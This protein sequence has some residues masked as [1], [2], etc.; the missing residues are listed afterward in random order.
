MN[1]IAQQLRDELRAAHTIIRNALGV[2]T[3]DQKLQW[4][5]ANERDDAIGEGVTRAN[6]RQAVIDDGS[7]LALF[8]ELRR[9]DL[10]IANA[11]EIQSFHQHALWTT[12][13][14]Q[15][16][17]AARHP[18]RADSRTL[19]LAAAVEAAHKL[20][21]DARGSIADAIVGFVKSIGDVAPAESSAWCS[22]DAGDPA[23]DQT[24][25]V[26]MPP[27]E[28]SEA[29]VAEFRR[30]F[31]AA[32]QTDVAT[33]LV[34]QPAA[35]PTEEM[36]RFC[37]EC[38]CL[39]DIAAGY[40]ACCPDSSSARIV[41]KRFAELC[42]ETF[43][44]CVSQPY[45]APSVPAERRAAAAVRTLEAK[46]YTYTDGAELWR[47]PQER[48]PAPVVHASAPVDE[49]EPSVAAAAMNGE[50]R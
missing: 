20:V 13:N 30:V 40:E 24:V 29:D 39:G 32:A 4:A 18:T 37:P 9:A 10:I 16:G 43:K 19:V 33:F 22:I 25:A 14:L 38:G 27:R 41:P 17:V 45:G 49:S 50:H 15:D 36:I 44:L 28:L 48:P 47:P 31:H 7:P 12:A 6:E 8:L 3:F 11:W 21:G 42:A 2:M 23:G 5:N 1:T 46:A 35:E 34:E 26:L